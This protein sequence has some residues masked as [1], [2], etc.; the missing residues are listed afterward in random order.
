MVVNE[1]PEAFRVDPGIWSGFTVEGLDDVNSYRQPV[2]AAHHNGQ[3]Q[4]IAIIGERIPPASGVRPSGVR[5][6]KGLVLVHP[7]NLDTGRLCGQL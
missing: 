6:V 4:R 1:C 2:H 7:F 3:A 5:L